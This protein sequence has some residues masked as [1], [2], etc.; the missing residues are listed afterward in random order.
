[1]DAALVITCMTPADLRN[2][3]SLIVALTGERDR[4]ST[5]GLVYSSRHRDADGEGEE[6]LMA[7]AVSATGDV[8]FMKRTFEGM[9]QF[10][11]AYH[12]NGTGFAGEC[13]P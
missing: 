9:G 5:L 13:S 8:T 4:V 7:L 2:A 3:P 11:C 10:G 12:W 6:Y 1:M